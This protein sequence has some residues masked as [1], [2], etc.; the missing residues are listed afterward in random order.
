MKLSAILD[1]EKLEESKDKV[2]IQ[3]QE[4]IDEFS[5]FDDIVD[6]SESVSKDLSSTEFKPS[7]V[8]RANPIL[9]I[10]LA[11]ELELKFIN[12]L[13]VDKDVS[14]FCI[15]ICVRLGDIL[16]PLGFVELT[17]NN[18]MKMFSYNKDFYIALKRDS[19]VAL[20]TAMILNL[21]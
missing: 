10:E 17:F 18:M 9:I 4:V 13:L 12:S 1:K 6:I 11:N 21:P 2:D 5:R 16:K 14:D 3:E 15:E 19:E 7:V 8:T 20:T